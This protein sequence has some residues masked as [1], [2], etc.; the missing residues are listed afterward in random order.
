[1]YRERLLITVSDIDAWNECVAITEEINKLCASK[2]WTQG[3]L[4]TRTVGRFNELCFESDYADLA[5]YEREQ[6]EWR[7]EPG[8][9]ALMRRI[10]SLS[11]EDPGYSELWEE[12]NPVPS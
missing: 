4:L 10:D 8:I 11:T 7:A 2:G 5:T 9:G 6:K 1:M 12:A 3:T